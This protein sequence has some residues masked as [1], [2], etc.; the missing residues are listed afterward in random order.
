MILCLHYLLLAL[1]VEKVIF[2]MVLLSKMSGFR[3]VLLIWFASINS[4]LFP[5]PSE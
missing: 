2:Q 5:P 3:S 4:H 1:F